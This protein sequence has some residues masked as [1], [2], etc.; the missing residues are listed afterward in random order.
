MIS[1][2]SNASAAPFLLFAN[3]H[4][5][6]LLPYA[7]GRQNVTVQRSTDGGA[8]WQPILLVDEGPSAYTSLAQLSPAGAG[9]GSCGVLFEES[10]D[11]PVDFR[12]IRL[13]TFDCATGEPSRRR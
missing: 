1:V 3:P 4:T 5:S 13:L 12:S 11:L 8:S 2:R 6:G 9:A 7:E 10:A